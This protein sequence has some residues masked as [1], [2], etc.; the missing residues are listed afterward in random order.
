MGECHHGQYFN[1]VT[2]FFFY[3][4]FSLLSQNN[5]I[6][7]VTTTVILTTLKIYQSI[8]LYTVIKF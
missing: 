7:S 5:H 1:Q 3:C 6:Y 4:H 2:L 8:I